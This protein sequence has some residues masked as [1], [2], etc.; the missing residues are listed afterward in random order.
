MI[1]G[2]INS[3]SERVAP[4]TVHRDYAALRAVL[5]AAL[6]AVL[7]AALRAV[8]SAALRAVLSAAVDRDLIGRNPA[9]K[10]ALPKRRPAD[11]PTLEPA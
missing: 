7:S 8:L 3:R 11:R 2:V 1:Q 10:V 9:R 5:S 6:R 4:A